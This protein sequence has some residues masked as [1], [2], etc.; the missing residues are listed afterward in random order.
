MK[1]LFTLCGRAG[2]QGIKGKN[3]R[4]FCGKYL[5]HYA[6]A[7]IDLYLKVEYDIVVNSDSLELIELVES[8]GMRPVT[9]IVRDA[10]LAGAA[11]GKITAVNDCREKM[12]AKN[13]DCYD[14]I[15]DMDITSPFRTLKNLED[16]IA[17]QWEKKADVTTTVAPARRNPYFNQ[18]MRTEHGVKKVI[19]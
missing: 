2:S 16:V 8:N 17:L 19:E 3:L 6:I 15:V 1:I 7:A 14:M 13:G 5:A 18:V 12:V 4:K 11:L 10:S 9:R